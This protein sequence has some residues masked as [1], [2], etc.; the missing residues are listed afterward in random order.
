MA[1]KE[2]VIKGIIVILDGVEHYRYNIYLKPCSRIHEVTCCNYETRS[3]HLCGV[4]VKNGPLMVNCVPMINY[5]ICLTCV[6]HLRW[7]H[8]KR[9][10]HIFEMYKVIRCINPDVAKYI[11]K[12]VY[13]PSITD[14]DQ[15]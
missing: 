4:C 2:Q 12:F 10:A 13:I 8:A 3:R 6:R 9:S 15:R 11:L 7:Q 5:E 14:M 1:K